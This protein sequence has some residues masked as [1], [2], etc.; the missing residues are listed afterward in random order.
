MTQT[1]V[2]PEKTLVVISSLNE[3][4]KLAGAHQVTAQEV[5]NS[6]TY[7]N[8]QWQEVVFTDEVR[9]EVIDKLVQTIGGHQATK[10]TVRRSLEYRRPQ[11]WAIARFLLSKY[12][13]KDAH[14]SYCAGQDMTWE[15]R[16]V[17]EYLKVI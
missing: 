7:I 3:L 9:Q 14:F 6:R 8:G 13:D 16:K 10:V 4:Y 11:H 1:T 15:M 17:R 5:L 2:I 12:G